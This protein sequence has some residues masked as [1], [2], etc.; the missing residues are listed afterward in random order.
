M[1]VG[2]IK[3]PWACAEVEIAQAR[4]NVVPLICPEMAKNMF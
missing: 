3:V 4:I 1:I 2:V